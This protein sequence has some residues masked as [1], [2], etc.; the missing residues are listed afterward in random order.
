M[1]ILKH[2]IQDDC[3]LFCYGDEHTGSIMHHEEGWEQ[4]VDMLHSSYDG[5]HP[6]RNWAID[7]GDVIEGI[8]LDDKR[9]D[10]I[11]TQG[12]IFLEIKNAIKVRK[13][14]RKKIVVIL[15]GNHPRKLWRFSG[16]P[17]KG[18][19]ENICEELNVPYGTWTSKIWYVD[20]KDRLLFKHYLTHGKLSIN[21]TADDPHRRKTNMELILK[22]HLKFKAGDCVLMSKGHTH[23]LLICKPESTLYMTDDGSRIKQNYTSSDHTAD[24]IHPDHRWY[25]NTGSFYKLFGNN[26]SGYGEIAEFDPLELG[27]LI[28]KVRNRIIVGVD[29]IVLKTSD[30]E[31]NIN[32]VLNSLEK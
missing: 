19:T 3:N 28:V 4:L 18:I 26:F 31:K 5:L 32:D 25:L 13:S 12:N 29:K 11:T 20:K 14:I 15:D 16:I 23:K 6:N 7:H 27:F 8:L 22:R 2:N 9:Y 17:N 10:G 21:S 30:A 1:K 24:N